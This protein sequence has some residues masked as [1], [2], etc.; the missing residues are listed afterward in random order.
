MM[1]EKR[2]QIVRTFND[3]DDTEISKFV[4]DMDKPGYSDWLYNHLMWAYSNNYGVQFE[5]ATDEEIAELK[6]ERD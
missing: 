4:R 5:K 2:L 3:K 1:V 6:A